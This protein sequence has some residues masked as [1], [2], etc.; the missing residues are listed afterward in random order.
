MIDKLE[1]AAQKPKSLFKRRLEDYQFINN[2]NK[3]VRIVG[4]RQRQMML[5]VDLIDR[6]CGH[7]A[8]GISIRHAMSLCGVLDETMRTWMRKGNKEHEL[9][10]KLRAMGKNVEMGLHEELVVRSEEALAEFAAGREEKLREFSDEDLQALKFLLSKRF[11]EIYGDESKI[12]MSVDMNA[13]VRHVVVT[14]RECETVDEWQAGVES[15]EVVDV[16]AELEKVE[17]RKVNGG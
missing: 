13:N 12:D 5:T 8:N 9:N 15:V 16:K 14:P 10:N 1:P 4:M 17:K 2:R 11:K 7:I 6:F 3:A